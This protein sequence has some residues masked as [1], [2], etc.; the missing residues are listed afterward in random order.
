MLLDEGADPNRCV[1]T[2][3]FDAFTYA[4]INH[5][6]ENAAYWLKRFPKWTVPF[7]EYNPMTPIIEGFRVAF[8]NQYNYDLNQLIYSISIAIAIFIFGTILFNK[9]EQNFIDTV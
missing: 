1:S 7:L 6:V 8:F 9:T 3:R 5:R 2:S 4:C